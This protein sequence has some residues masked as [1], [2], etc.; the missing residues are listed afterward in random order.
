M[1]DHEFI[2]INIIECLCLVLMKQDKEDKVHAQKPIKLP[3]YAEVIT[4]LSVLQSDQRSKRIQSV[5]VGF[6]KRCLGRQCPD[7]LGVI[8]HYKNSPEKHS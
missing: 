5:Q 1:V 4:Y 2:Q 8:S 3:L 6:A 7:F